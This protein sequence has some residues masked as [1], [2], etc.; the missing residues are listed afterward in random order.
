MDRCYLPISK[1]NEFRVLGKYP[2][3]WKVKKLGEV[4]QFTKKPKNL[5]YNDYKYIPFIPMEYIP[6]GGLKFNQYILK[7]NDEITSGT[8]FEQGDLLVAK[9]TPS[10]ENGK[11]GIISNLPLPFGI[12]TTEVIPINEINGVSDKYYL[13]YYLLWDKIRIELAGKM[14]GSTGRQRLSKSTIENTDIP[15]PPLLEQRAIAKALK[16][17]QEAKEARQQ[18]LE[19]ELERK[20]ALMQ[21]LFT[22]GTR[23]EPRKQTEI[24]EIP[25]SWEVVKLGELCDLLQYGTSER[26]D[27]DENGIPVIGIPNVIGGRIDTSEL[28]YLKLDPNAVNRFYLKMGDLLFVRT[29]GRREYV[30]RT[31]VFKDELEKTLFASYLIRARLKQNTLLPDWV[32]LYTMTSMG[33]SFLSGKASNAADGKFNINTQTIKNML[34]PFP[35]LNEQ[36]NVINIAQAMDEKNNCLEKEWFILNELFQAMLEELMTG[37]L[38]ALPLID[39][40]DS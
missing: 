15:F 5:N 26:C 24:G 29:N 22:H 9:I 27:S 23:G 37:R 25:Q 38:S 16:A 7:T 2:S 1:F 18:E 40:E 31:A 14:E 28:K 4:F 33:M 20:A 39:S 3:S 34:I 32:Q 12:A 19:L 21:Y 8:Y 35:S 17:V 36:M 6:I 13:S 10:F 30:G 11:Q